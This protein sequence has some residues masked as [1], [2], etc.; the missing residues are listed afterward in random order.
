MSYN[1]F[2]SKT[3]EIAALERDTQYIYNMSL[4]EDLMMTEKKF[5]SESCEEADDIED[6]LDDVLSIADGAEDDRESQIN[7][8]MNSSED[9]TFDDMIES[10][11]NEHDD[12]GIL[13]ELASDEELDKLGLGSYTEASKTM[14]TFNLSR[15]SRKKYS[16]HLKKAKKL[17]K[18]KKYSKAITELQTAKTFIKKQINDIEKVKS[19]SMSEAVVDTICG[20]IFGSVI[21]YFKSTLSFLGV[22]G[23]TYTIAGITGVCKVSAKQLSNEF[24]STLSYDTA[25]KIAK[26]ATATAAATAASAG[27]SIF[28][29][30]KIIAGTITRLNK[31]SKHNKLDIS[32]L[33]TYVSRSVAELSLLSKKIDGICKVVKSMEK[34][35]KGRNNKA[36]KI[37]K[38]TKE[39]AEDFYNDIDDPIVLDY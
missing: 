25:K 31:M 35:E 15:D 22:F 12:F 5:F 29:L 9:L 33:N 21:S 24:G 19:E 1:K 34:T 30:A 28:D 6:E 27:A 4:D 13:I 39:S 38:I 26:G 32:I 20:F 10:G 3:Y 23:I 16:E 18:S 37:K 11:D 14:T 7:T 36:K 2:N 8:I 17:I